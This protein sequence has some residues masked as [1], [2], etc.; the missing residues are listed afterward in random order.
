MNLRII[1]KIFGLLVILIGFAMVPSFL[2]CWHYDEPD[3]T[4]FFYSIIICLFSGIIMFRLNYNIAGKILLREAFFIVGFGWIIA[5]LFGS[6]PFMLSGVL[7][8]FFD[9]FFET[10]SG[11]T[12][13]GSSVIKDVEII[14][15]GILFWRSFTHWLG[16][17]GIIVLFVAL[18]P[19]LGVGGRNLMNFESP[20]PVKSGIK[21]KT[22]DTA[23]YLWYI[24]FGF[25]CIE[26]ILLLICGMGLFD[27]L[28]HTFG[29]M[30]TG[31]FSTLN[32]SVGGFNNKYIDVIITFFMIFAGM[33]FSL[34]YN[35]IHGNFKNF[36][37]DTEFKA[38]MSIIIFSTLSMTAILYF[39]NYYPTILSSTRYAF[40][41]VVSIL[42]TTGYA[43][44]DFNLWPSFCKIL[45]LVL[46]FIGG[47]AGSTGG[48][49][50]VIRIVI[51]L[52]FA[53]QQLFRTIYPNAVVTL[54]L[55]K[56][57]FPKHTLFQILGF[58]VFAII[59]FII[60]SLFVSLYN[61]DIETS[62]SAVAATL[63]NIG[64]GLAKVGAIENFAFFPSPVK[65]VL[66][67]FMIIG[68]LEL[69]TI[70]VFFSP[71]FWKK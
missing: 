25:T 39:N 56:Q 33:N 43:T 11:F 8:D 2:W 12:T 36:F 47:C 7:P 20:G 23:R 58:F 50:K 41:Q 24:Y 3:L 28:C 34:Y 38:Y 31:G 16:G 67:I 71:A 15:K 27:S 17:M 14:G 66:S 4:A 64:P 45:F 48:G 70:L 9:A 26:I 1:L 42:T 59:I 37:K 10:V 32:K 5:G 55:E 60:G 51:L 44:A 65:F 62:L 63:W 30:A 35:L 21:P 69:F 18:F 6:L 49:M 46:M 57:P 22:V 29:T 19:F 53:W 13:T 54:K 61:F 52:K 40:F 68:R